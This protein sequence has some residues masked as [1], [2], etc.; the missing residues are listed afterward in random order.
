MTNH[1]VTKGGE[2]Y[3]IKGAATSQRELSGT[4]TLPSSKEAE[5]KP[6]IVCKINA[7]PQGN[8]KFN[9]QGGR[10]HFERLREF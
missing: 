1:A 6:C 3:C 9:N 10:G 4:R 5:S 8:K 7:P 2:A